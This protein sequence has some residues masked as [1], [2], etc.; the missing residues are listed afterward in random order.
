VESAS[1][2]RGFL[3]ATALFSALLSVPSQS[4]PL[5]GFALAWTA[6]VAW[7]FVRARRGLDRL[8][9][10]RN[11]PPSAFE[12]DLVTVDLVLQNHG[13]HPIEFVS[14]HDTFGAGFGGHQGVLEAGPLPGGHER[15][16]S[17][18]AFASQQW[19]AYIVG[20]PVVGGWDPL[21]LWHASLQRTA[22][23]GLEV[24]PGVL[25]IESIPGLG[26]QASAASRDLTESAAGQSLLFR[27]AREFRSG[28]DVRRIHWPATA[29]RGFPMVREAERDVQPLLTLFLDLDRRGRAGVGKQSTL[30]RL[31]RAAAALLWTAHRRQV[32]IQLV[33]EGDRSVFIPV[34]RGEVH[35]SSALHE[36]ISARQTGATALVDLV[37]MHRDRLPP[38]STAALLLA[39]SSDIDLERLGTTLRALRAAGVFPLVM[40]VHPRGLTPFEGGPLSAAEGRAHRR[41]FEDLLVS[42]HVPY[43]F[44]DGDEDV[45]AA[46]L[47]PDLFVGRG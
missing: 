46:L 12:G 18:N 3:F 8:E 32:A 2:Y 22:V 11:A 17:Y 16:L 14:V 34:G 37:E 42:L 1:P 43:S 26:A 20:P 7:S 45:S 33:A 41:S 9:V 38:G 36:V 28:D 35:L 30:D 27:G 44:F 29:Q 19:G 40:A 15:T 21:G 6:L 10:R 47:R 24:F 5:L 23:Q 25:E 31:V 13:S 39:G 4:A